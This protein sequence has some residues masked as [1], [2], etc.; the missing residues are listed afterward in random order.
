M[1]ERIRDLLNKTFDNHHKAMKMISR[2][3]VEDVRKELTQYMNHEIEEHKNNLYVHWVLGNAQDFGT[4]IFDLQDFYFWCK[5]N[6][7]DKHLWTKVID[8]DK[9]D[10]DTMSSGVKEVFDVEYYVAANEIQLVAEY[11]NKNKG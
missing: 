1:S 11:F 8:L 10:V 9:D 5:D 7:T 3:H 2:E 6:C 4:K